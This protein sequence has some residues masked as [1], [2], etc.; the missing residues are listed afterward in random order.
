[1]CELT[2]VCVCVCARKL[3]PMWVLRGWVVVL[4]LIVDTLVPALDPM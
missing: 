1:M 2:C 4:M 3:T